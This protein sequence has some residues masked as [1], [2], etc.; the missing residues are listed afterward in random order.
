MAEKNQ[1]LVIDSSTKIP[2]FT[3]ILVVV[4]IVGGII[5]LYAGYNTFQDDHKRIMKHDRILLALVYSQYRI[6]SHLGTLPDKKK[7]P[8]KEFLEK[9]DDEK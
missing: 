3:A 6:E 5:P 2:L 9:E 1:G 4:A 8:F 7:N